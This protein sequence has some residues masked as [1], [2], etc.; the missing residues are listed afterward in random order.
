VA[1]EPDGKSRGLADVGQS[2]ARVGPFAR[3]LG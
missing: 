3:A 2:D 1:R